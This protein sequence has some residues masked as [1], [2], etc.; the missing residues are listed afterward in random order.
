MKGTHGQPDHAQGTSTP[1]VCIHARRT[2]STSKEFVEFLRDENTTDSN[3]QDLYDLWIANDKCPPVLM[4]EAVWPENFWINS[5][6][7]IVADEL[8][9]AFNSISGYTYWI[10]YADALGTNTTWNPFI[11]NGMLDAIGGSSVFTDD[12]T[13]ATSGSEP[14]EGHRFYRIMR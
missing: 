14:A 2:Q 3:G 7:W 4:T 11:S 1:S 13:T 8:G 5:I 6:G 12:F 9:I 10:E